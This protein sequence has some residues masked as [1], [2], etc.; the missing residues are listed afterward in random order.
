MHA[1]AVAGNS[2]RSLPNQPHQPLTFPFPKRQ[3]GKKWF[4]GEASKFRGL[5]NGLVYIILKMCCAILVLV[6][7]QKKKFSGLLILI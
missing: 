1:T 6:L 7:V 2:G 4:V 3:F 5:V